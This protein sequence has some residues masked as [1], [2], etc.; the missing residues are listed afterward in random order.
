[1]RVPTDKFSRYLQAQIIYS[2]PKAVFTE[3]EYRYFLFNDLAT[4]ALSSFSI[5]PV[6]VLK[7]VTDSISQMCWM[8]YFIS[9]KKKRR[10]HVCL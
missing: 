1:M 5:A 10:F 3:M 7:I 6:I 4:F 8:F 9:V 2:R